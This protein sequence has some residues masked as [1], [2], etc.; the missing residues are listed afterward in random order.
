MT[1]AQLRR[2]TRATERNILFVNRMDNVPHVRRMSFWNESKQ[3]RFASLFWFVH[4]LFSLDL[5]LF[6]SRSNE[7]CAPA[8]FLFLNFFCEKIVR[9]CFISAPKSRER[10]TEKHEAVGPSNSEILVTSITFYAVRRLSYYLFWFVTVVIPFSYSQFVRVE[11]CTM[12][13]LHERDGRFCVC[14]SVRVGGEQERERSK[15]EAWCP[16]Y[17]YAMILLHLYVTVQNPWLTACE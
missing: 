14:M 7:R 13:E 11:S 8:T 3:F 12:H 17:T 4:C 10:E 1:R 16:R 6:I 15:E 9:Y 2:A 5:L